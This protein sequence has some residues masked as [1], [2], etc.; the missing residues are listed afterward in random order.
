MA[1]EGARADGSGGSDQ[2]EC[3]GEAAH[4]GLVRCLAGHECFLCGGQGIDLPPRA[5]RRQRRGLAELEEWWSNFTCAEEPGNSHCIRGL[6]WL[7]SGCAEEP[8]QTQHTPVPNG[9]ELRVYG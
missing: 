5:G 8:F 1:G 2:W 4:H 3:R 7:I 9:V 6:R